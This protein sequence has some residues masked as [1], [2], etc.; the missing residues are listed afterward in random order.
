MFSQQLEDFFREKNWH[1]SAEFVH[2]VRT[3][4]SACNMTGI[5]A[6]KCVQCLYE[7]HKFLMKDINFDDFPSPIGRYIKGMPIQTYEAILQNILTHLQLYTFAH[8]GN[9]NT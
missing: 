8:G 9:Y 7:M 2:I 1:E 5:K 6:D 3:W 4:H